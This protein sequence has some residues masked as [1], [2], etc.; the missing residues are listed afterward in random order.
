MKLMFEYVPP[1]LL[2]R[3]WRQVREGI[4]KVISKTNGKWLP[5]DIYF[6]IK[7]NESTLHIAYDGEEYKGFLVLTPTAACDGP[8]LHIWAAYNNGGDGLE[9]LRDGMG[10]IKHCAAQINA[11]RITFESPRRGWEKMG[12][13]LG[14]EMQTVKFAME[15]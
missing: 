14:F 15:V 5:E 2:N 11:V 4:E 7:T 1:T 10:F 9:L 13:S 12:A 6:S 8:V 3:R